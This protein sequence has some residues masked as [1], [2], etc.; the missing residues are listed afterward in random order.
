MLFNYFY[1][2]F[3]PQLYFYFPSN[4]IIRHDIYWLVPDIGKDILPAFHW[5]C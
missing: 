4:Y 1:S 5:Y 3:F 2:D